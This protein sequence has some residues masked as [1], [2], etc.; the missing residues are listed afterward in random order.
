MKPEIKIPTGLPT[1]LIVHYLKIVLKLKKITIE[2]I[3]KLLC[4]LLHDF[5]TDDE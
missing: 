1:P 2:I 4:L 3:V 5:K